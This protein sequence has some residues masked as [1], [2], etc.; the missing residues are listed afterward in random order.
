MKHQIDTVD[1]L[2]Y[3]KELNKIP[4]HLYPKLAKFFN[5]RNVS[6]IFKGRA[7][8]KKNYE[9]LLTFL[10]NYNK[11]SFSFVGNPVEI[12]VEQQQFYLS[13]LNSYIDTVD[14]KLNKLSDKNNI[15]E[16][17]KSIS[18]YLNGMNN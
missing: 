14:F 6:I 3:V 15:I 8:N 16:E 18:K 11:T 12:D 2:V 1:Y 13:R 9:K 10:P 5:V 7:I 17:Q 4:V